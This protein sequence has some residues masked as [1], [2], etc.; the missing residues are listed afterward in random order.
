MFDLTPFK[1]R[2]DVPDV[3]NDM[4]DMIRKM[5]YGFPFHN[6]T[7]DVNAA[8]APRL[9]VSESDKSI[10]IVADL[11][12]MEKK[13]INVSL[14]NDL[15]TIKGERKEEKE[16]KGKHFHTIERRSGSFYRTLR[17]PT[18]VQSGKINASFKDGVLKI[19]LPKAKTAK[20]KISQIEV[21]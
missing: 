11:P 7:E 1:H 15:L 16:E 9:D 4:E 8:W 5:W 20:K 2:R 13:D 12:G 3:F 19:T 18:E 21:K 17:L 14:E 6:L 10:E